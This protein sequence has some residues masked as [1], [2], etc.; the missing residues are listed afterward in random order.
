MRISH[1][2]RIRPK[3]VVTLVGGGGKTTLMFCL[4]GEL[5]AAG[6]HVVTTMTTHI[7]VG[8]MARAPARLVL[9]AEGTL[10]AQLPQALAEHG[11]VLLASGTIVEKDKVQG[12][13]PDL[14]DRVAAQRSVDAVIIEGDGARR[15]PFKAPAAHEPVIPKTATV[16][17]PVVGLDVLGQPLVAQHVHRPHL[18][19]ELTAAAL[20]DPVTPAMI[21][22]ML[23]HPNGGAKNVPLAA[24]LIPFLNK[25][26]DAA[27]LT[28]ARKI[29]RLLLAHPRVEGVLIGAA[30][31]AE[32]V[33][34]VWSRVGVVV[35]AAGQASRY[36]ALK[37][38][39][40]WQD[41]LPLVAHV[42]AQTL[43]CPD[44]AR[45]VVTAGAGAAQVRSAITAAF[46][47]EG[48]EG[49]EG[50][51]GTVGSEGTQETE[52]TEGLTDSG[53]LSLL[54]GRLQI[55]TVPDW[56]EGQSRSVQVGLELVLGPDPLTPFPTREGGIKLPSPTREG[57]SESDSPVKA[58][59]TE[60]PSLRRGGVGGEVSAVLFLLADQP[61]VTTGLLS[62]LIQR[63]RET[64]APIVAPRYRGQRGNPVL[65]DR[66]TFGEFAHLHGDIG[67]RPIVQAHLH[68][69]AWVDWPTPEIIQ[70]IDTADDYRPDAVH[71]QS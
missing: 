22:T 26:E 7:F 37:Q 65:F 58:G 15:L 71:G 69:I 50:T 67:A 61:G 30:Q 38:V 46:G 44:V 45:V 68:E 48:S 55:V 16:V 21:A 31:G 2:L 33:Q 18:V 14:V 8:Q 64:L 51:E 27:T 34:E 12:L 35:L 49:D 43:A 20:G 63:H 54:G 10:L 41:G 53:I 66:A 24:R 70:D 17:I 9:H 11:H 4:A 39:L 40:P 56:A 52:G 28:A 1:A 36:G 59:R 57:G 29:A 6:W 32:P 47:E 62:A 19:A 42:T 3:D 13:A 25:V 60:L 5:V 23:A